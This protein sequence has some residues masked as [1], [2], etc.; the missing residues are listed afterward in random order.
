VA[1]NLVVGVAV[2]ALL[3]YRQLVARPV[4][5]SGPKIGLILGV[6]GLVETVEFLG[7][8]TILLYLGVT[9]TVQRVLV[10]HRASKLGPS[11]PAAPFFGPARPGQ[12]R[13]AGYAGYAACGAGKPR[14]ARRTVRPGRTR[15]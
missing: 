10:Q 2:L 4:S 15:R 7:S 9:F 1:V 3:I 13:Y 8:A 11:G 6:I 5:S 14:C 12:A